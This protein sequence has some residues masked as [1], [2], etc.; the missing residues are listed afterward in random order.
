[1]REIIFDTETTGLDPREDRII[2]LGAVELVN[3]FPTGRSF[4]HYID[5]QGRPIDPAALALVPRG[6][7]EHY[8][9]LPIQRTGDVLVV[10]M[11]VLSNLFALDDLRVASG[12]KI[13][14]FAVAAAELQP[15]IA[16]V[17]ERMR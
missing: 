12:L 14:P 2:E 9:V 8:Q 10:A 6:L 15:V 16:A 11:A 13:R 17:L 5:P 1:M 3:R 4:H 7:I